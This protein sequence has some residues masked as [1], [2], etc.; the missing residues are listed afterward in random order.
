MTCLGEWY[1]PIGNL[2]FAEVVEQL[3]AAP[4]RFVVTTI[5]SDDSVIGFYRGLYEKGITSKDLPTISFSMAEGGIRR[6]GYGNR[7]AGHYAAWCYFQSIQTARNVDFVQKFQKRYGDYRTVSDPDEAAYHQIYLFARAAEKARDLDPL[8]LR[9][10]VLDY[11]FYAPGGL[12]KVDRDTQ[13]CYRTPRVG[14]IRVDGHI[15][16]AWTSPNWVKPDPYPEKFPL[17]ES[18]EKIKDSITLAIPEYE[19]V[20]A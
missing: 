16:I 4:G 3:E 19:Y 13:H 1:R 17:P 12:V 7:T 11:E 9:D 20:S 10:E 5:N 2:A 8:A 6:V 15:E 14:E 18:L